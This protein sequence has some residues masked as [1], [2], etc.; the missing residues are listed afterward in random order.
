MSED[1]ILVRAM[2]ALRES[3]DGTHASAGET[4]ARVLASARRETRRRRRTVFSVVT[5]A[6]ALFGSTA[7]AAWTGRLPRW[8][9]LLT[10]ARRASPAMSGPAS[11]PDPLARPSL[12]ASASASPSASASASEESPVA[13]P[14]PQAA[15]APRESA[16]DSSH[17]SAPS[18]P[19]AQPT[20]RLRPAESEPESE[21][22]LYAAAH[23]AHFVAHDP[24]AALRDWDRY[25]AAYPHGHFALEAHYN[26]AISLVRL[27]RH[28]A[29][30]GEL[31]PFAQGSYG[32]YRQAEARALLD[33]L[34]TVD[35]GSGQ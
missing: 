7:W 1:D 22:S 13:P 15:T 33:A 19:S 31:A 6:A 18:R 27:G 4:R 21:Q 2:H 30:R 29:A 16:V 3:A 35:A 25:L 10:R 9:D 34:D 26:R 32:G 5:L 14:L 24:A 11:R 17:P 8:D 28:A 20:P 23:A 12:S